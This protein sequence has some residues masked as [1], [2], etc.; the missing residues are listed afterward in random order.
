M[1]KREDFFPFHIQNISYFS[2]LVNLFLADE[3]RRAFSGKRKKVR[4]NGRTVT[5]SGNVQS[6]AAV[7]KRARRPR[8]QPITASSTNPARVISVDRDS[9][10]ERYTRCA[11]SVEKTGS[12]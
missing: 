11:S 6:P 5:R 4:L 7:K 8:R 12:T 2:G 1:E 9:A 10:E 3:A